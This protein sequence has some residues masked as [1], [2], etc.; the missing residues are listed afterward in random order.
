LK[1]AQRKERSM[2]IIEKAISEIKP[3][4]KNPRKNDGAVEYV[5]N[6]I[7]EFGF[8]VPIVIDKDGVIVCGHTRWKAAKK[9]K[10]E[11]VPCI[12]AD[13]LTP[14]QIK[15][16][17]L[18]DN[19]VGEMAEWDLDLLGDELAA[20][21]IDMEQFGFSEEEKKDD[22]EEQEPHE[23]DGPDEI[24][25]IPT[26]K[27]GEIYR[28]GDH[29][30]M[31]GDSTKPEDVEALMQGEKA[32]LFLTDPPY[33]VA[34]GDKNKTLKEHGFGGGITENIVGDA[35]MTDEQIGETLWKPAFIQAR[36]NAKEN[37]TC[38]ITMPQGGT[39][40]MMMMMMNAAGWQ[41][42]HEL[43][44]VK[45]APTFSLGRLDYDYQHEPILY[46][47]NKNHKFYAD[48]Y[49]KSVME[50]DIVNIESMDA[51]AMKKLLKRIFTGNFA[52]SIFRENKP[53]KCDLHPTMKPVKLFARLI[54][55]SSRKGDIVL[56]LFGG[57]GT[58]IIACEQL[59]R[60]CYMMEYDPRYVDVIIARWEKE[61]GKK[62]E[63]IR[64]GDH[65]G[66][67]RTPAG[68]D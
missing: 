38:Y 36:D 33:N 45:N 68:T 53:K 64:G 43:I 44:W 4:E 52:T 41:V 13:D 7:R 9:L 37:C 26:A 40:M 46:G 47:W 54:K 35:G 18:A 5:A 11:A 28:L 51:A 59:K 3:Y 21:D 67:N 10:L 61:T 65:N 48:D 25:A 39:H 56:D 23:D 58:T 2:Q 16:F 6:S 42:K 14:E 12:M 50:E 19:K 34:I 8:K 1:E 15:A 32:D 66:E 27:L 63:L 17:R 20:L 60:R 24:P 57:S 62:A 49:E 31:C 29:Y 55:N 22:D 30:L